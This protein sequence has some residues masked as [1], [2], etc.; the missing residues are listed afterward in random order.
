MVPLMQLCGG[1]PYKMSVKSDPPTFSLALCLWSVFVEFLLIMLNVVSF[2]TMFLKYFTKDL[3]TASYILSSVVMM[4]TVSLV[5]IS[6]AMKSPT[7]AALIHD[8]SLI[9]GVSPPPSHRW[10]CKPKTLLFLTTACGFTVFSTWDSFLLM[11]FTCI[12]EMIPLAF[13]CFI[14]TV[15]FLLPEE[16]TSMVF[17]LLARRLVTATEATVATVSTLLTPDGSECES[18]V[19]GAV[20]ALRNLDAII[21]EV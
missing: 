2:H 12:T 4:A 14:C 17:G 6:M 18:D 9:E 1:F 13:V 8:M 20:L 19:E 21:Q 10:Y 5:P 16:L 15:C 3:G 11:G 7:L